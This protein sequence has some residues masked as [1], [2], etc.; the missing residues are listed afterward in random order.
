[1]KQFKLAAKEKGIKDVRVQKS[2]C[3]D[4]CESGPTCVIYPN[5]DWFKITKQSIPDLVEFLNG[6]IIPTDYLLD[7]KA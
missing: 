2:G 4:F 7:I 5:G 3:L 1:M 6:G